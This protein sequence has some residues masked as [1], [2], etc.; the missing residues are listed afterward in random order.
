[1]S[2]RTV[3]FDMPVAVEKAVAVMAAVLALAGPSLVTTVAEIALYYLPVHKK[4][5]KLVDTK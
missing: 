2:D 3:T 1:M 5:N 4:T